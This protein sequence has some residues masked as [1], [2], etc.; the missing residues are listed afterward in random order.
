MASHI[1]IFHDPANGNRLRAAIEDT[2]LRYRHHENQKAYQLLRQ[3]SARR[4][5]DMGRTLGWKG[6]TL[7]CD[8]LSNPFLESTS[9]RCFLTRTFS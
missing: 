1:E 6:G 2:K 7:E 3:A 5:T 9:L 4:R 8:Q